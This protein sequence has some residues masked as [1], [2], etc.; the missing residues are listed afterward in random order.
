MIVDGRKIAEEILKALRQEGRSDLILGVVMNTDDAA[1]ESFVKIKERAAEKV[2]VTLKRFSPDQISEALECDGMIVQLP[3]E[4]A[5][6]LLAKIPPEKDVDALGHP[7]AGGPKVLAPVAAAV[8]EVL[9]RS[10]IV[11][12]NKISPE[13]QAVVVGAGRLVGKPCAKLLG[14]LGAQVSVVTLEQGSLSDLKDADIIVSGAGSPHL[15]KP[16]MLKQNV[17]LIDAGMSELN[18]S[19]AGDADPTCAEVASIFTP[20]PGGIGP[21][22]VAMIYKNLFA[23]L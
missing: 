20:T 9:E 17:V 22:A 7:P 13:L 15:I 8:K 12:E 10:G 5:D 2:G 14:D 4:N 6:E 21:I 1:S 19:L 11:K 3:I 16:E 18:G 23:L